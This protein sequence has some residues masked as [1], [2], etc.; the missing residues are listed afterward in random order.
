MVSQ[1]EG[2]CSC[3]EVHDLD[4]VNKLTAYI[5]EGLRLYSKDTPLDRHVMANA[6]FQVCAYFFVTDSP[7][8]ISGQLEEIENFCMALK[9]GALNEA[10]P[11]Q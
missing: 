4:E 8:N 10:Q 5:W 6:F 1:I 2:K 3:G 7:Q 11:M 9:Q